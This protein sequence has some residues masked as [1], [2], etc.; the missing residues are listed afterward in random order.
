MF[1]RIK[2]RPPFVFR[3]MSGV[4]VWE[5]VIESHGRSWS[6]KNQQGGEVEFLNPLFFPQGH[7]PL[8]GLK[9]HWGG[10]HVSENGEIRTCRQE[11]ARVQSIDQSEYENLD[12]EDN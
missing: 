4:V 9:N 12:T 1:Q 10:R 6:K 7:M 3:K 2:K 11:K 8:L 5:G